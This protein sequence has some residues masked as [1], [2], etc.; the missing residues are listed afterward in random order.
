MADALRQVWYEEAAGGMIVFLDTATSMG[1]DGFVN[2]LHYVPVSQTAW[3]WDQD[4]G[5]HQYSDEWDAGVSRSNLRITSILAAAN[6]SYLDMR[7]QVPRDFGT[8]PADS[9]SF[10]VRMN[11]ITGPTLTAT[12][13]NSGGSDAGITAVDILPALI[14]TYT[15][16]TLT[17]LDVYAQGDWVTLE[18]EF[19]ND[20]VDQYVEISDLSIVYASGRG[21]V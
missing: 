16:K 3:V 14:N 21:N 1:S 19:V 20:A 13:F 12:L 17:P 9:I 10:T 11:D 2:Y 8:F 5:G 4:A 6:A 18:I 15:V 7:I